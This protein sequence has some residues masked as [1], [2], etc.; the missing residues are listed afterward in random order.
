MDD[1]NTNT[2]K[3]RRSG[4][5]RA[6]LV[7]AAVAALAGG[8]ATTAIS[9][10]SGRWLGGGMMHMGMHGD[11]SDPAAMGEHIE[12]MVAHLAIEIDA[13]PEQE[14]KLAAIA[15]AAAS[16]LMPL[17]EQWRG[18]HDEAIALL[19]GPTVD[20]AAIEQ[21]RTAHLQLA[22]TATKRLSEALADAAEVL[23]VEQRQALAE[24]VARFHG[25]RHD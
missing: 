17:R 2:S 4:R 7:V 20:R 3:A 13:T 14:S 22:D 21:F 8:A 5:G 23:T 18:A 16:D 12:K 25:R 11:M 19:T 24:R 6:L 10:E 1:S 15:K 9:H